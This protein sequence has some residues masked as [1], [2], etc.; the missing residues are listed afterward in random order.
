MEP[1]SVL[2]NKLH[3]WYGPHVWNYE[4]ES[5]FRKYSRNCAKCRFCSGNR[6]CRLAHARARDLLNVQ[7]P[8][9]TENHFSGFTWKRKC[10]T[11][12]FDYWAAAV[13][14]ES[15]VHWHPTSTCISRAHGGGTADAEIGYGPSYWIYRAMTWSRFE[16]RVGQNV[17]WG[18]PLTARNSALVTLAFP[19][20]WI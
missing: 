10:C 13:E 19:V 4:S 17:A 3:H 16:P 14:S 20:Y 9:N 5:M 11:T 15:S 2:E 8:P 1:G 6:G 12:L 18:A 7:S